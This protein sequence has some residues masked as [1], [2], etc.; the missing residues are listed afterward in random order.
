MLRLNAS[1]AKKIPVDGQ[2]YSSQNVHAAVELELSDAL[3]PADL[4]RKIHDT[5]VLVR[6]AVEAE[7][8]NAEAKAEPDPL[9]AAPPSKGTPVAKA[10]NK[11]IKFITDLAGSLGIKL[12][13][14]TT[15]IREQYGV[16]SLYELDRKQASKLLDTL[17]QRRRAA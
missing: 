9:D 10:T 12:G 16:E 5:F 6:E 13:E 17:N 2:E 7:L 14:L 15:R 11:Q 1:Y 3:A 4:R 8:N